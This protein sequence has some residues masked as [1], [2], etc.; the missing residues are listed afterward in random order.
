MKYTPLQR[1]QHLTVSLMSVLLTVRRG[2]ESKP[3]EINGKCNE[4]SGANA[5][6]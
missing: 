1:P 3:V 4:F 6:A 2:W 5:Y